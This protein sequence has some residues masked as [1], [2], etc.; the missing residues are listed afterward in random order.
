MRISDW[1]SD[2]CS[3]DLLPAHRGIDWICISPKTGSEVEQRSGHELKLVW[4]QPGSDVE[5]LEKWAFDH[6]LIQPLDD[7]NATANHQAAIDFVLARPVRRRSNI[8]AAQPG[9]ARRHRS[10]DER[11]EG[12]E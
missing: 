2:V 11:S 10:S 5:V 6:F 9:R 8:H 4:P 7:Q 1:S 3:S 12:K